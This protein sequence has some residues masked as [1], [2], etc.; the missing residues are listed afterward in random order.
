ME[1]G[2]GGRGYQ[3][4]LPRGSRMQKGQ[5]PVSAR[6]RSTQPHSEEHWGVRVGWGTGSSSDRG[7]PGSLTRTVVPAH[8]EGSM[9]SSLSNPSTTFIIKVGSPRPRERALDK[10]KAHRDFSLEVQ[11][12]RL[13]TP[14][15]GARVYPWSGN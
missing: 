4:T 5:K 8:G 7:T 15:P 9:I 2:R 12:L 13:H 6:E 1:G 10:S 3:R 14:S 11:W